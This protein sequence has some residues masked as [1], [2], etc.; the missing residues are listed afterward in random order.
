MSKLEVL[1]K[2][3]AEA[4]HRKVL[5]RR[6]KKNS[7]KV[8]F[9]NLRNAVVEKDVENAWRKIFTEYYIDNQGKD[10][11]Y[12][13]SSPLDVD[14]FISTG[15]GNLVFA[16]RI[17]M[18]FKNGTDLTKAYD[19]ARIICQCIH[20]MKKFQDNGVS[21]PTVIVGADEDQAFVL[22][23]T[24][25]YSYL[26]GHYNWQVSPSSAYREDKQ[27]MSKLMADANLS[28]YPFQFTGGNLN[29]RYNSLLDLF[30]SIDSISQNNGK[31]LYKVKVS[32]ATIVGMFDEFNHIAFREPDKVK[33]VQSVNMFMHM[34][35][36]NNSEDYYFIP[37]N[38][39]LYHLPGDKK[40]AVFGVK[41]E[42]YL[43]HYDRNF[44]VKEIDRLNSIADRLIEV[45]ER[46]FKGDF[47]TPDVWA[48]EADEIIKQAVDPSYKNNSLIWDCAAGVRNL[49]R[50]FR[51]NELFIST[52]HEDEILLGD[53][54]NPEAKEVFQYDFLND[55]VDLTP[56]NTPNSTAWKLPD[57][58]FNAL[59][60]AG[61]SGK[62]V[63]FYTN[64]P[65]GTA[66]NFGQFGTSKAT[67]A[68]SK[69]NLYMKA[70]GFGKAAQQLYAQFMVRVMKIIRDFNLKNVYIAFFTN[71]RFLTGADYWEKFNERFFP[72]FT[73]VKGNLFSAG[74]FSDTSESWPITF[75][76]YKYE[77]NGVLSLP[78]QFSLRLQETTMDDRLNP[79]IQEVKVNG[80]SHK[81]MINVK[82][83]NTL[84]RWVKEPLR[85]YKN[86]K[87]M[88]TVPQLGSAMKVSKG[89]KPVGFLLEGSLG[90]MVF[91]SD[92]IGKGTYQ[93]G[94][95]IVSGS[96]YMG[97]GINVMPKGFDRA[98]V[99]FAARKAVTP[100]W[101]NAQ[102]NY[103]IPNIHSR[104][105]QEFINDSLVFSLFDNSSNQASYRHEG[106]TNCNVPNKWINE[107]FW[108][109]REEVIE[110][111]ESDSLMKDM[112]EDIRTDQERYVA[113][114]IMN[115]HF[116]KEAQTV[117]DLSKKVW[118]D[119]LR[120][121]SIMADDEPS[122]YL[123]AWDAGWYQ[124]KQVNKRYQ[125]SYYNEF[126]QAFMKLKQ[127]IE[128]NT[129]ALGML[130]K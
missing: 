110:E 13:I 96:A 29:E 125:S 25:F 115:R 64:P 43:N 27:L 54:Y 16:L 39:N 123:N 2:N 86:V 114:E 89:K 126:R 80:H 24:K 92:N 46:R 100:T 19:R 103:Q 31:E 23:A 128:I 94:V 78:N 84:N 52:Y 87:K 71:A 105:Y 111:I 48:K 9:R 95:Y 7:A 56:S 120:Y 82:S 117:L 12:E 65:Y 10:D 90:Y 118:K 81:I 113:K 33:P 30:D 63:I 6:L 38:R 77:P 35:T 69:V 22:V 44:T 21:L 88:K 59:T 102:D 34:I 15:S 112:Y 47:W 104:L 73:L 62:R 93:G 119:T 83:K 20:Y 17:L 130:K 127:K 106:W 68:K 70:N 67:I 51:Y 11:D 98:V 60:E 8:L 45:N 53:G 129:Y 4:E 26:S 97:H 76:V 101:Y 116:S 109:S 58:L 1:Q 122:L 55:D 61:S 72:Q 66:N 91:N 14:G 79:S 32:P 74:E 57:S 5:K 42:E 36:G 37:R 41:I 99:G 107:W 3:E 49:T 75:A 108:I 85:K 40:V 124:I 18:E 50:Q 28:V 121:R